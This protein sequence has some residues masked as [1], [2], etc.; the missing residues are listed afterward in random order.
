MT[1]RS[2]MNHGTHLNGIDPRPTRTRPVPGSPA[3]TAMVLGDPAS[4]SDVSR[5]GIRTSNVVPC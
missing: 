3:H 1:E 4:Q 5:D 2:G